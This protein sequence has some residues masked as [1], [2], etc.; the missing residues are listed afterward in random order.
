MCSCSKNR[1]TAPTGSTGAG[2]RPQATSTAPVVA[3][4]TG[5]TLRDPKGVETVHGSKLEASAARVR[6]GGG[7][8]I[9]R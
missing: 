3:A 4:A 6:A 5:Y 9:P 2:I 7:T 1:R 8:I